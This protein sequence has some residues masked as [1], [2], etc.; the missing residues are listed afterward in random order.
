MR[1]DH[2]RAHHVHLA[3]AVW[4]ALHGLPGRARRGCRRERL[5]VGNSDEVV[6]LP[7]T[8]AHLLEDSAVL[9]GAVARFLG[10]FG[11]L[12]GAQLHQSSQPALPYAELLG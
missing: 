7:S 11:S 1:D 8:G 12:S 10:H 3:L 5:V 2:R 6:A 4:R 9:A